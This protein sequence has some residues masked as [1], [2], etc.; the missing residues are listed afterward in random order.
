VISIDNLINLT[1]SDGSTIAST[2][3]Y[4]ED[5]KTYINIGSGNV[6]KL[7]WELADAS[8]DH[9]NLV[10]KRHDVALNLYYD[11]FDKNIGLVNEFYVNADLL[12]ALPLQYKLFIYVVAFKNDGSTITSNIVTPYVS[13]G[14]GIYV[15]DN[16]LVGYN[17]ITKLTD[18]NT[19]IV[20]GTEA[21][22]IFRRALAFVK[23]ALSDAKGEILKDKNNKII[24]SADVPTIS[25]NNFTLVS[26]DNLILMDSEGQPLIADATELLTSTTGWELAKEG[27]IKD[28]DSGVWH[29]NDIK[30]EILLDSENQIILAD[31]DDGVTKIVDEPIYVL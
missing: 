25:S 28:S 27:Y 20:E 10:I 14:T 24:Y 16:E 21:W 5:K 22:P 12:P 8:V 18:E 7:S 9:Y 4:G 2:E 26:S 1:V 15:K 19:L 3:I 30:Y 11:I 13:K 29:A 6:F 23:I 31:F 17:K